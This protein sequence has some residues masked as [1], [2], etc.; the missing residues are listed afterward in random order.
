MPIVQNNVKNKS[1]K[2]QDDDKIMLKIVYS[3]RV[4]VKSHIIL[5]LNSY[6]PTFMCLLLM[7][8][9]VNKFTQKISTY[10]SF[11]WEKI[12]IKSKQDIEKK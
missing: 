5:N 8:N 9:G 2:R 11:K 4:S 10:S 1:T 3:I 6:R 7:G 12:I